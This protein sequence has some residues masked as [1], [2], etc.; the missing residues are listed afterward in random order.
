MA[1]GEFPACPKVHIGFVDVRD[2]AKAHISAIS[3]SKTDG[4]RIILSSAE[5]NMVDIGKTLY[6]L[7]YSKAPR[8]VM[9]NFLVKIASIFK[10]ELAGTIPL[11]GRLNNYNKTQMKKYFKWN[12]ITVKHSIDDTAKQ[13]KEMGK[14]K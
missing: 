2:V 6:N 7:G 1:N 4:Q 9:P 3:D 13:L 10:G 5:E 11:L 12:F 8:K 14:I